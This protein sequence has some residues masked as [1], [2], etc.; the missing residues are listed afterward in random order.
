MANRRICSIPDCG[1]YVAARG[2]C[3]MH[4]ARLKRAG[5]PLPPTRQPHQDVCCAPEC[6]QR[7]YTRLYCAAHHALMKR[8]GRLRSTKLK[9]GG[10]LLFVQQA[11]SQRTDECILWP[12]G[13]TPLRYP[14]VHVEGETFPAHRYVC[15]KTHGAPP[16]GFEAAHSCGNRRC[17]NPRHLRWA[18]RAE[19][20][21][22]MDIHG[23]RPNG[24]RHAHA[25]LTDAI[26]RTIKYD[27][28]GSH[29]SIARKYGITQTTVSAIKRGDR[30]K[31]V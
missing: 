7:R 5:L 26:A 6:D 14:N 29:A 21:S 13:K 25:K 11:M 10:P 8:Q 4:L 31:H 30:W 15:E 23:T 27:E 3:G 22:D 12:T 19:N 17:V 16:K 2:L 20:I 18:T 1:K 28:I 24:E 9:P